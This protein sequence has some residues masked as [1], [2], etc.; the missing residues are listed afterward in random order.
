[1]IRRSRAALLVAAATLSACGLDAESSGPTATFGPRATVAIGGLPEPLTGA[2]SGQLDLPTTSTST[3]KP[4]RTTTTTTEPK[5]EP[6][7]ADLVEG[8][9]LLM[10]GDS[11]LASTTPRYG[12]AMCGALSSFGWDVEIDAQTNRPM[13]FALEVL[14]ERLRPDDDLDWDAVAIFLGNNPNGDAAAFEAALEEALDVI[15]G[16]PTLLSTVSEV[17]ARTIAANDVIREV[18]DDHDNVMLFDWAQITEDGA[19]LVGN[20]GVHLSPGG[21]NAMAL[22]VAAALGEAPGFGDGDCLPP[23]FSD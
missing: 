22:Y 13:Q 6:T 7:L 21:R 23:E 1:M 2:S 11:V 20:D 8:R 4:P 16:R 15:D 14:D 3:T 12:G 19:E 18:A 9:R 5:G 10:I 17:N